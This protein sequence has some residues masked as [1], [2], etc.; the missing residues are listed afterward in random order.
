M[1]QENDLAQPEDRYFITALARGLEVLSAF[2]S[3]EDALTNAEL[4][5][6][7][8]LPKATVTRVTYTLRKLGYLSSCAETGRYRLHPHVLTLGYPVLVNLGVRQV[9]RPLMQELADHCGGTVSIGARD[10][11]HMI[12]VERVRNRSVVTLPLDVGSCLPIATSSCGRAYIAA[13]PDAER[14]ALLADIAAANP[15]DWPRLSAGIEAA[16][17]D[18][19]RKGYCVSLGDWEENV[20]AV[21]AP[22]RLPSGQVLSITC[23]GPASRIRPDMLDDLGARLKHLAGAVEMA[24]RIGSMPG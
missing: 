24:L 18:Y 2:R 11:Q 7:T 22:L 4:S 1:G 9:A 21:G 23:G 15:Q 17:A 20:N 6:R 12:F 14:R 5:R 10:M 19:K 13:I 16:R 3:G 8:G